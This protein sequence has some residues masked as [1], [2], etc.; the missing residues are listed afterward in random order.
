[1]SHLL[2]SD[3]SNSEENIMIQ[4]RSNAVFSPN[5]Q[6]WKVDHLNGYGE[7]EMAP[8][9]QGVLKSPGKWNISSTKNKTED[10]EALKHVTKTLFLDANSKNVND[11]K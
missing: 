4:S 7:I 5:T 3:D 8:N 11:G 10:T 1:L 9:F 6:V 2:G